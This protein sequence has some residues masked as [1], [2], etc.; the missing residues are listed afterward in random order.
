MDKIK[1]PATDF[2]LLDNIPDLSIIIPIMGT[3]TYE[4]RL[5]SLL[6]NQTRRALMA[7][8]YENTDHSFYV[9]QIVQSINKG[10]GAVQR[11]LRLM[12]EAGLLLREKKGN[13]VYYQANSKS[14]IFDELRSIVRKTFGVAGIIKQALVPVA[15]K[16]R[17]AF[18][19]G[20]V[21]RGTDDR[22]SDIDL[23]LIGPLSF[24]EAAAAVSKAQNAI[25]RE[26]NPIVYPVEEFRKRLKEKHPFVM[27]VMQ[28]EKIFVVG[29]EDELGKL[30]V[31]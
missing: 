20:S 29:N 25:R 8:F 23:M 19:F 28:S 14:P 13:Q 4:D 24:D 15:A 11:E 26:I 30:A 9:N 31:R 21:A 2:N 12:T 27:E 10:S 7:L 16:I 18:I 1:E 5:A 3:V 22:A 6:F 17:F